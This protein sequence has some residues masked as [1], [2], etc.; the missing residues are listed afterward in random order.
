MTAQ[1]LIPLIVAI[2]GSTGFWTWL[3][4]RN[5]TKTAETKLLLGLAYAEI[6]RRCEVYLQRGYI[7]A[8]EYNEL[9]RYL[10]EPYKELGGDGTAERM[11]IA[12]KA[13]PTEVVKLAEL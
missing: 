10:Y 3:L 2:F 7:S 13:L 12:V 8:D 4:S 5:K 6:I 1:I 9:N 11:M